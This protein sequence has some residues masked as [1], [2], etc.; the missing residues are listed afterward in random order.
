VTN[1][2]RDL[3]NLQRTQ[4]PSYL[5]TGTGSKSKIVG[6]GDFV[7]NDQLTMKNCAYAPEFRCKLFSVSQ[8]LDAH[9][10][11]RVIF[12]K[13]KGYIEDQG[14]IVAEIERK[15]N[16]YVIRRRDNDH[17][18]LSTVNKELEELILLH[19]R[20]G[21]A[22]FMKLGGKQ[23]TC[24]VCKLSKLKKTR[25]KRRE[26]YS[27]TPNEILHW[28]LEG[29]LE[30]S[31]DSHR[32]F[33]LLI[34]ES[35]R[36]AYGRDM[37]KKSEAAAYTIEIIKEAKSIGG[38]I[39]KI[40]AD[41]GSEI[42]SRSVQDFMQQEDIRLSTT[43]TH[44]PQLNGL[45][46]RAIGTIL[47]RIRSMLLGA[48]LPDSFWSYALREAITNY[49]LTV[50]SSTGF[51]PAELMLGKEQA[52][53]MMSTRIVFG[54]KS[55]VYPPKGHKLYSESKL[56][57]RGLKA[58]YL[59]P[60]YDPDVSTT[61]LMYVIESGIVE[62][63]RNVEILEGQFWESIS[64]DNSDLMKNDDEAYSE[65][66]VSS[67]EDIQEEEEK[68][69]RKSVPRRSA[70][71]ARMLKEKEKK[72]EE[73]ER[74]QSAAEY[75]LEF[76]TVSLATFEEL[77]IGVPKNIRQALENEDWRKSVWDEFSA[78]ENLESW[79]VISVEEAIKEENAIFLP[80]RWI[81]KAKINAANQITKLKSR[82]VVLGCYQ[83]SNNTDFSPV[84]RRETIRMLCDIAV[85]KNYR[86]HSM[87]IS[88]AFLNAKLPNR[89][90]FL[91]NI[92]GFDLEAG[93]TRRL[94]RSLY[95]LR[96]SPRLWADTFSEWIV[97]QGL[98]RSDF[99]PCIYYSEDQQLFV[100]VYVDDLL[101]C[102][103]D[104][105]IREFKQRV[106]E[107][108]RCTDAGEATEILGMRLEQKD[109]KIVLS[110]VSHIKRIMEKA[111]NW[112]LNVVL[113]KSPSKKLNQVEN[114]EE[115]L[116]ENLKAK[117]LTILGG[118]LYISGQS[119]P[120]CSY[121]TS[122]VCRNSKC[123]TKRDLRAVLS[124]LS[125]MDAH[126]MGIEFSKENEKSHL[127][128]FCDSN[129]GRRSTSGFI[130]Y[131]LTGGII[132]W[133]SQL[134]RVIAQS[135]TE[136]EIVAFCQCST[137]VKSLMLLY[138]ELGFDI[139]CTPVY[140]DNKGA[141]DVAAGGM[142][143]KN[144][145]HVDMKFD[146]VREMMEQG[147]ISVQKIST[148]YQRADVFTKALDVQEFREKR[149]LLRMVSVELSR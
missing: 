124:I 21:H 26:K 148:K 95:G 100:S 38:Q 135:S 11:G 51:R 133:K 76:S 44:C 93:Y 24:D 142:F 101:I 75:D 89:N 147:F 117:F 27:V 139:G 110:Q 121:A 137:E 53:K 138:R 125:Y 16:L 114:D 42:F 108:F 122:N 14:L 7:M 41:N 123:P 32:Y 6:M 55:F 80:T 18:A 86:I 43:P 4:Q 146:V 129:W 103:T 83:S 48:S 59:G 60:G 74:R 28:D 57:P 99:D 2:E 126:P 82:L 90:I 128:A 136:A 39:V 63:F 130:I 33:V 113:S 40:R 45:C 120:D 98:K 104:G 31:L 49:N 107:R 119:R 84:V 19:N 97:S 8:Y 3:L 66:E 71:I 141:F 118:V 61:A 115:I 62:E 58:I 46:E 1:V 116:D 85:F 29:P 15:G 112:G 10:S 105:R 92:G 67:A 131:G 23:I 87:D 13:N 96:S 132:F 22:S 109:S 79:E 88:N 54:S 65:S 20:L 94:L 64:V 56:G 70:R 134:Q 106:H 73:R 35:T 36:F 47:S 81:F 140:E 77:D 78:L 9:P 25:W 143:R 17:L 111:R 50:H 68:N 34:E 149:D 5:S 30:L 144:L 91:K 37:A 72:R 102:G 127:Q 52:D 12:K 145:K 69:N